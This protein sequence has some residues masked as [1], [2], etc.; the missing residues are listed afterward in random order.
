MAVIKVL[1][2]YADDLRKQI[3]DQKKIIKNANQILGNVKIQTSVKVAM[4]EI[5]SYC[6]ENIIVLHNDHSLPEFLERMEQ[7][8][9][10]TRLDYVYTKNLI[11]YYNKN[12]PKESTD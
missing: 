4:E 12:N 10:K 3:E 2:E 1:E 11:R 6:S 7:I 8:I 9:Y 5:I